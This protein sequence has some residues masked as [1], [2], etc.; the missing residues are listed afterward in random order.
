MLNPKEAAEFDQYTANFCEVVDGISA[1]RDFTVMAR[2]SGPR[3]QPCSPG[4]GLLP[5]QGLDLH[6]QSREI[7]RLGVVVVAAGLQGL[8]PV[9]RHCVGGQRDYGNSLRFRRCRKLPR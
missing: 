1:D 3:S 9:A 4:R 7:H 2:F 8:L 6:Q 5:D